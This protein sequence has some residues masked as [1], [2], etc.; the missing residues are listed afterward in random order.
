MVNSIQGKHAYKGW[1]FLVAFKLEFKKNI[2]K[3]KQ[4]TK[5][6]KKENPTKKPITKPNKKPQTKQNKKPNKKPSKKQTNKKNN[7]QRRKKEKTYFSILNRKLLAITVCG[8]LIIQ[9][10]KNFNDVCIYLLVKNKLEIRMNDM[11]TL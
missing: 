3:T 2:K 9:R 8:I 5:P 10:T 7:P 1:L 4:K 6:K 11:V